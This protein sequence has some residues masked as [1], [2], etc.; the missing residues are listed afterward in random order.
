MLKASYKYL[1]KSEKELNCFAC[2]CVC[3]M[4]IEITKKK[5]AV[6]VLRDLCVLHAELLIDE[7]QVFKEHS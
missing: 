5:I 6:L 1:Y 3:L 4:W 2:M 7:N